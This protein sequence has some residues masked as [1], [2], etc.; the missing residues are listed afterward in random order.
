[1]KVFGICKSCK[2]EIG[3]RTDTNT[4]VEFAMRE[5]ETKIL[6]CKNCGVDTEFHVDELYAKHSKSAQ[7]GAGLIFLIGTPLMFFIFRLVFTGS[8][9]HYVIYIVSGFLL[10]PIFIYAVMNRQDQ[11]RV[12]DFNKRKLK[13]RTH[14]IG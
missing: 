2:N 13:G 12:S 14:N 7:Y 8:R 6:K 9:N 4:R 11:T 5:S 10:V 3:Y 1:M